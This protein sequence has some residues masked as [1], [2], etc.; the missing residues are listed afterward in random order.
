MLTFKTQFPINPTKNIDDFIEV[1]RIWLTNSPHSDLASE[2]STA[3]EIGDNWSKTSGSESIVFSKYGD[4]LSAFRH[5]KVADNSIR[6]IL[7][8]V[9]SKQQDSFWISIQ[10]SVDSEL[11]VE[12]LGYGKRPY[13]QRNIISDLGGGMDG[14]L[15]V[16]DKP[17]YLDKD[18]LELAANLMN[19]KAD[20][21]MPVV[22]VSV[23]NQNIPHI[24]PDQLAQWLTGMAH[25]VV[26][27]SRSFSFEL[28]HLTN[29]KNAYDGAVTIYWPDGIGTWL[30]LPHY[31]YSDPK[32]MQNEISKKIRLSLLSQRTRKDC[33]W[34][35]IQELKSRQKIKELKESGSSKVDDYIAAF[36]AEIKSKDEEIKR[37]ENEIN[38]I[39]YTYSDDTE[40]STKV[41]GNTVVLNGLEKDLYQG[42]RL[43]MILDAIAH[44]KDS[45]ELHSRRQ[46]VLEDF[47]KS[48]TQEGERDTILTELKRLLTGYSSMSK[49]I[50]KSFEKLGFQISEDG[51][52]HK[53]VFRGDERYSFTLPKSG[54]D[55]RGGK[56]AFTDLKKRMF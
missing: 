24:N 37:L 33:T 15:Q 38:R 4:N 28:M 54:S 27:P 53:L 48:N 31:E 6:W 29:G 16:S 10:L 8:A 21:Q 36:D 35:Y 41:G 56:N 43:A 1:G 55:T 13:I 34:S 42:E 9:A 17:I 44:A 20:C 18:E 7:E 32:Q 14:Q 26:E 5:E 30:F 11:P 12:K 50:K 49:S 3:T 52:H 39:K 40:D 23:N 47:I 45:A 25:V 51:K 19:A 2:L 22:Y 46:S